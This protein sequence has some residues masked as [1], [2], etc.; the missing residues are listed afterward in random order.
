M[1]KGMDDKS[2]TKSGIGTIAI[3]DDDKSI[4][5]SLKRV[6]LHEGYEVLEGVD[7][8][9]GIDLA[10]QADLMILDVTMPNLGGFDV[11]RQLRAGGNKIPIL[12]LT[13]RHATRDRVEGLDAGADDYLVKPFELDELLARVR[14][15]IRRSNSFSNEEK[16]EELSYGGLILDQR[17]RQVTRDLINIDL[18]KT[19]FDLLEIFMEE[20]GRVFN[21]D[22]LYERVWGYGSSMASNSLDVYIGYLRRKIANDDKPR[23]LETIRGVGY[24]LRS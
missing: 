2:D 15:L 7:G 10:P 8:R 14:S 12:C 22:Q 20:P 16:K 18:T 23:L 21:R 3:I 9:M 1:Y 4:R 17:T 6:L 13:A 11:C 5:K 24:V 19:E